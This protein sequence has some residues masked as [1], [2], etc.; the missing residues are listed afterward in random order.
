MADASELQP[1]PF[2]II[3]IITSRPQWQNPVLFC[4]FSFFFFLFLF[5]ASFLPFFLAAFLDFFP[6]FRKKNFF[7][8]FFFAFSFILFLSPFLSFFLT[9]FI[10]L[11][12]FHMFTRPYI[13]PSVHICPSIIP[14]AFKQA[15]A[16]N[17]MRLAGDMNT[18]TMWILTQIA[19]FGGFSLM[20]TNRR[21][22]IRTCPPLT[23][24]TGWWCTTS[25]PIVSNEWWKRNIVKVADVTEHG[26]SWFW[27][28]RYVIP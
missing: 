13:H 1:H 17:N 19:V 14:L 3:F 8:A 12:I 26:D 18:I 23:Y 21:T 5:L 20:L 6:Y 27:R 10:L 11:S 28:H 4:F 9:F 16:G 2:I 25:W 24:L 22:D 7:L 15:R